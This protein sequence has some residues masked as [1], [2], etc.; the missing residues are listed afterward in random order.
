VEEG[1]RV[2]SRL[3]RNL[4]GDLRRRVGGSRRVPLSSTFPSQ[5]PGAPPKRHSYP[6]VTIEEATSG[7]LGGPDGDEVLQEEP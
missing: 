5:P 2:R 4:I 6:I 1:E 7:G 3:R